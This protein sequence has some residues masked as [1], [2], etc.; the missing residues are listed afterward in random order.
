MAEP[1]LILSDD[2]PEEDFFAPV[3]AD[4]VDALIGEYEA[5]KQRIM[6]VTAFMGSE[7]MR[8]AFRYFMEG[9]R[10]R[11][12][13]YLPEPKDL[14]DQE[15]ALAAL[16]AAFWSRTLALTD[17]LDYMPAARRQEWHEQIRGL[18][19]PAFEH[20]T[21]RA[22]L[23]TLL[24]SRM[25]FFSEMVEGIFTG[26][27]HEHVTNRPEGF[28]RRMIIDR[29]YDP[30]LSLAIGRKAGLIHDLRFVL[31]RLLGRDTP[32]ISLTQNGLK[33]ARQTPGVWH[34]LDGNALR[35]RAYMKGTLH[36]EVHPDL[37]WRL[38]AILAH[39]NPQ[40]IPHAARRRPTRRERM[41]R[42]VRLTAMPVPYA[43]LNEL[44]TCTVAR[45]RG[46]QREWSVHL[47]RWNLDKHL[48]RQ[49]DD[50]LSAIGGSAGQTDHQFD[51]DP[52]A[53]IDE[54]LL[55]GA[56]PERRAH[57]YYPTPA[58]LAARLVELAEIG[59]DHSCLEPSAGQGA[60]A[61]L[62]P[63]ERT[64]CI[65]VSALHCRVLKERGIQSV[66]QGDFLQHRGQ[67]DRIVMNPPFD[68]GRAEDHVTHAA[69]C[70][71]PGGRLVA[72]VPFG[73]PDRMELPGFDWRCAER[74]DD[75]FEHA[76]INVVPLIIERR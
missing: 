21:V 3:D 63:A 59:P 50:V 11:F 23:Q 18:K 1:A 68:H 47:G 46:A 56:L 70:L 10:E 37:A 57:Q 6:E 9:S 76:T 75:V 40:A 20:D 32:N 7:P 48:R 53:V 51:Y 34:S 67:Y 62:L 4:R 38:N 58:A 74:W 22:T 61:R 54:L 64:H 15:A 17:V 2:G 28:S 31:A 24:A 71:A 39:R 5:E 72:V 19:T 66:E 27:S 73:L 45:Q 35:I 36:L 25:D 52:T 26:L 42:R 49:I 55:T 60:I 12:D 43:V 16:D 41:K 69:Q 30:H 13:R 44:A 65:E 8:R 14:L 29:V 33:V